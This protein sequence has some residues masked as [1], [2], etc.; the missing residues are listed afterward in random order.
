MEPHT[1]A[2]R[3]SHEVFSPMTLTLILMRHAKSSWGD[4]LQDDF[5][6]PLNDRGR[7]GA[8]L[9][10]DWLTSAELVPH[11][12]LCSSAVRAK[13]T[14][15]CLGLKAPVTFL[16][17]LYLA[18]PATMLKAIRGSSSRRLMVIAHNPGLAMLAGD[19]ASKAADHPRFHDYP[20]AATAVMEFQIESWSAISPRSGTVTHFVI[21]ADLAK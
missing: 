5:D 15:E 2:V 18:S 17:D 6:R 21:P 3:I 19:L 1:G 12:V 10:G 20:T 4:P 16:P 13:E 8:K 11:D 7:T 9:I 14:L